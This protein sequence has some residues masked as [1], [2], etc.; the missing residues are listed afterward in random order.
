MVRGKN[1]LVRKFASVG[2]RTHNDQVMS[3]TCSPLSQLSALQKK[4]SDF[5]F[6]KGEKTDNLPF[7]MS[8]IFYHINYNDYLSG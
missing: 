3:Q 1:M 5:L 8:N 7:F 4:A 2:Y 6:G